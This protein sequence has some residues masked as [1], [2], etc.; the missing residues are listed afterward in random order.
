MPQGRKTWCHHACNHWYN[1]WLWHLRSR[2]KDKLT[3]NHEHKQ[4]DKKSIVKIMWVEKANKNLMDGWCEMLLGWLKNSSLSVRGSF[5]RLDCPCGC[6]L[7]FMVLLSPKTPAAISSRETPTVTVSHTWDLAPLTMTS[8][9][10]W[11]G[12]QKCPRQPPVKRKVFFHRGH[13][14]SSCLLVSFI[15]LFVCVINHFLIP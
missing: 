5:P 15:H 8:L 2:Y 1:S 13:F 12:K 6:L 10:A 4:S 9:G 11:R 3:F 7:S 14:W